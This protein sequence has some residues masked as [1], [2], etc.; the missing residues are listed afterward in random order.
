MCARR[1]LINPPH[2]GVLDTNDKLTRDGSFGGATVG[3]SSPLC[4]NS[5]VYFDEPVRESDVNGLINH[6]Y[7]LQFH[8]IWHEWACLSDVREGGFRVA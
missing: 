2:G 3:C 8:G 7:S 6:Q 4:R 5:M 1:E